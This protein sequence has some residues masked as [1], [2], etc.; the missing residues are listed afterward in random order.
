[1][2]SA[3]WQITNANCQAIFAT[4]F[5]RL[6]TF[7]LIYSFNSGIILG[8]ATDGFNLS[9]K[10]HTQSLIAIPRPTILT[11][12]EFKYNRV[13]IDLGYG[14]QWAFPFSDDPDTIRVRNFG[15]RYRAEVKYYLTPTE[16]HGSSFP[17]VSFSYCK[18]YS[19]YNLTT[20]WFSGS[21]VSPSLGV[22]D[23]IHVYSLNWGIS[24]Y[25]KNLVLEGALGAGL[26]VRNAQ[27]LD[28]EERMLSDDRFYLPNL[29]FAIRVGYV[30]FNQ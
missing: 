23:N 17:F 8:Q 18:I 26:R 19:R 22:I 21:K 20:D 25:H 11:S 29:S 9:F 27:T 14:H 28:D 7:I 2:H 24:T 6:L 10:I 15:N 16:R 30:F 1:M 5:K 4:V 13:G 3:F 12:L